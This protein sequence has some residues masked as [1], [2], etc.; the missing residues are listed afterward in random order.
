MPN[1]RPEA[2]ES[3]LHRILMTSR[4]ISF[5]DERHVHC[6]A[7][8]CTH[9]LR[10][11]QYPQ[12]ASERAD[13]QAHVS[14]A[15]GP[16][17]GHRHTTARL[18]RR[19]NLQQHINVNRGIARLTG[20][21]TVLATGSLRRNCEADRSAYASPVAGDQPSEIWVHISLVF[22][23]RSG[24]WDDYP[25]GQG[26]LRATGGRIFCRGEASQRGC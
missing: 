7:I 4:E 15:P 2:S 18:F 10:R 24:G 14:K 3:P 8:L 13:L 12:H 22:L 1:V 20:E 16:F 26:I 25:G 17:H 11:S 9:N 6:N 19:P 21:P 5:D 23:R